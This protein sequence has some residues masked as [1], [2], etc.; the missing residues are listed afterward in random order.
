MFW[1]RLSL[2]HNDDKMVYDSV[3]TDF[4]GGGLN[5]ALEAEKYPNTPQVFQNMEITA[6]EL[7]IKIEFRGRGIRLNAA[8]YF[9]DASYYHVTKIVNKTNV[10]EGIDVDLYSFEA[11]ALWVP[12]SVPGLVFNAILAWEKS[13]IGSG[14][15]LLDPLNPD[16]QLTGGSNDWHMMKDEVSEVFVAREDA[17]AA[18]YQA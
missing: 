4:K 2:K 5:P 3:S 13:K 1:K 14:E 11:D 10:N 9:C 12:R 7:G 17:V 18:I 6:H 16:L 15:S 8:A